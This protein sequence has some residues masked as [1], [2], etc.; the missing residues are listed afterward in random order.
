MDGLL[1][2]GHGLVALRAVG[3]LGG[4]G[5]LT[6]CA[7]RGDVGAQLLGQS[8]HGL[9]VQAELALKLLLEGVLAQPGPVATGQVRLEPWRSSSGPLPA[10]TRG[11]GPAARG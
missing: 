3:V 10:A 1:F 6:E 9:A 7:R 5:R 8:L 2:P 4:G 11:S